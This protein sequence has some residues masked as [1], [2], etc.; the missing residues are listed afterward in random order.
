MAETDITQ[1]ENKMMGLLLNE[2]SD[3]ILLENWNI[4]VIFQRP[5]FKDKYRGRA[6]ASKKLNEMGF[7]NP[8]EEDPQL[9]YFFQYW[10]NLNSSI[11]RI[12]V[13]DE[14]GKIKKNG[15]T[16]SDYEF[17]SAE[18][19][20]YSS[21]FEKYVME[22]VYNKGLS[23]EMLVSDAIVKHADWLENTAVEEDDLK[24]S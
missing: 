22:E 12:L 18:D 17:N 15:K 1:T 10:G 23:E 6:W 11:T 2:P 24:N 13:T 9:T 19:L 5:S 8:I 4:Y 16:Y 14:K 7:T 3:F 21:L 20:D